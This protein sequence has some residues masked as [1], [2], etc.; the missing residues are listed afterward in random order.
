MTNLIQGI[1][2]TSHREFFVFLIYKIINCVLKIKRYEKGISFSYG[3][4][5]YKRICI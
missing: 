4:F 3:C 2:T 5:C 1:P